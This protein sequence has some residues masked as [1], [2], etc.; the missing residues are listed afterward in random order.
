MADLLQTTGL[1]RRFDTRVAV[2]DLS[3]SVRAGEIVSLLGP[4]GA[5]KTTTFRMLAAL[6][7]PSEGH[8]LIDGV[9]LAPRSAPLVRSRVGLLTETPGLW[10]RLSV[11]RNLQTHAELHGV[12]NGEARVESLMARVG[13]ADR[14]GER[15]GALSKG[16]KQR[17]AIA[18]ALVHDPRVVLLDE[19]TAGLD[20]SNARAVRD[21]VKSLGRDGKAV[22]VSTHNL[23]EAEEL[24]DRIAVLNTRLLACD[25]PDRLRERRSDTIVAI[26][27]EGEAATWTERAART[28]AGVS[29]VDGPVL[30]LVV[31]G[32]AAVPDVVSALVAAGAR[33]RRVEPRRQ[34]LED[35][36]LSLVNQD[37]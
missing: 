14:A 9:E 8:V 30:T 3:L 21:I 34:S 25:T 32:P 2:A 11:R 27:V 15:A 29:A 26:E 37:D 36:Y 20:P 31:H 5:G 22:L 6:I 18:R 4:N 10:E 16:L 28:G 35:A 12:R 7:P 19:P 17:V 33:V 1:T 23:P 24:S 13:I